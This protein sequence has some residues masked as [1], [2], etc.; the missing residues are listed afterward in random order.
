MNRE[1]FTDTLEE[2]G[3]MIGLIIRT[4]GKVEGW[5]GKDYK[6][7]QKAVG[8]LIELVYRGDNFD[9]WANEE[10]KVLDPV[11][12]INAGLAVLISETNTNGLTLRTLL[13]KPVH[14]DVLL[15]GFGDEGESIT[16]PNDVME[17]ATDL[18]LWKEPSMTFVTIDGDGNM[19]MDKV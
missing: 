1:D 17:M 8:G 6:D 3:Y 14:G 11:L 12:P 18:A 19:E 9:V 5:L 4:N 2:I 10:G 15:L 13:D 16:C 7:M